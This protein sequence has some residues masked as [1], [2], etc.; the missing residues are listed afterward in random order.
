MLCMILPLRSPVLSLCWKC[1]IVCIKL[2]LSSPFPCLFSTVSAGGENCYPVYKTNTSLLK[3][4]KITHSNSSL[5][6]KKKGGGGGLQNVGFFPC[7]FLHLSIINNFN[8]LKNM[9]LFWIIMCIQLLQKFWADKS[10]FNH[11]LEPYLYKNFILY[12]QTFY[13]RYRHL[14]CLC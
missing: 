7:M 1:T 9:H 4:W 5:L 8:S 3:F 12:P 11:I 6:T 10:Y 14:T 13:D 2:S